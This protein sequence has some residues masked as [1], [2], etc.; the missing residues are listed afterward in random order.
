MAVLCNSYSFNYQLST[1]LINHSD[2]GGKYYHTGVSGSMQIIIAILIHSKNRIGCSDV[3]FS[4]VPKDPG[5]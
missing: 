1:H 4:S 2:L 3:T 5:T